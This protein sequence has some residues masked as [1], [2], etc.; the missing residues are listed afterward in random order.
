MSAENAQ[1]SAWRH[2]LQKAYIALATLFASAGAIILG[3]FALGLLSRAFLA[4]VAA[5]CAACAICGAA[6]VAASFRDAARAPELCA[7]R[8]FLL[9]LGMVPCL[10]IYDGDG[11]SVRG[12]GFH[13]TL[14]ASAI[15]SRVRGGFR[16][17][18]PPRRVLRC[19]DSPPAPPARKRRVLGGGARARPVLFSARRAGRAVPAP[20]V[21]AT[22]KGMTRARG[23]TLHFP[24]NPVQSVA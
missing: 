16:A 21:G 4:I 24:K 7:E 14:R 12:R 22:Q 11:S 20:R 2:P 3:V 15:L 17:A 18:P 9:K 19:A 6:N 1:R 5:V 23:G 10:L 8:F 13:N